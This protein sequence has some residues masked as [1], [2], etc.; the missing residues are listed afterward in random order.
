MMTIFLN[1]CLLIVGFALLIKGADWLVDGAS[2]IAMNFKIP[3]T[4]IGL[5]IVAFGTSAPELA[6][7]FQ[8]LRTNSVDLTF[9]NVIGSGVLNIFLLIGLA[10]LV[11]PIAV[12]DTTIKAELPICLLITGVFIALINDEILGNGT[13]N[14][15]SREDAIVALLVFGVFLNYT[16]RS[17][18]KHGERYRGKPQ[19][20]IWQSILLVIVG[21]VGLVFG[22]DLVVDSS[23]EIANLIGLSE[24]LIALTII[25]FGTSL[26]E[27]VTTIVS[28]KKGEQDLIIGN[29]IGS[30][31]FNICVVLTLPVLVYGNMIPSEVN[32]LDC[33]MVMLAADLLFVFAIEGRIITRLNGLIMLGLFLLYYFLVM[34]L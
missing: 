7:S 33:V 34:A 5:T 16:I 2:S 18:L 11:R 26:P 25:T 15:F 23:V 13:V 20:G 12:K 30:N 29:I 4:I 17:A 32:L 14:M 22:S 9:G 19:F 27:L 3:K 31:I 28:S 21:L 6:V 1:T 24:R 8:A 10:A